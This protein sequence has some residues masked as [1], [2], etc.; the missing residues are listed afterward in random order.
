MITFDLLAYMKKNAFKDFGFGA[1]G[2][3]K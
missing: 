1:E 2:D 3:V